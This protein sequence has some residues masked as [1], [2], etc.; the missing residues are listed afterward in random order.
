MRR[1][2]TKEQFHSE[3]ERMVAELR[4][5]IADGVYPQ[6]G[7]LPTEDVLVGQYRLSNKSVRKGLDTLAEE[8]M[9]EKI[10]RKGTRVKAQ[11]PTVSLTLGCTES[12]QR[13]LELDQLLVHFQQKHPWIRVK[14][15]VISHVP[16]LMRSIRDGQV[17]VM[18]LNNLQFRQFAES[19]R[20]DLLEPVPADPDM[21]AFL[22]EVFTYDST[23]YAQPVIFS[24]LVLCYNRAHFRE[25]RLPEPDGSWKWK[26]AVPVAEA[27]SQPDGRSGFCFHLLSGNRWP[28]FLLQSGE[29]FRPDPQGRYDIRGTR[30]LDSLRVCKQIIHNRSLF[31]MFLSESNDEVH[32][33]FL[34]GKLSMIMTTYSSLNDFKHTDLAYDISPLPFI[35]EPRTLSVSIGMAISSGTP[36]MEAAKELLAYFGAQ[37]AQELIRKR[38]LSIPGRKEVAEMAADGGLNRPSRFMLF[39]EQLFALRSHSDLGLSSEA[40]FALIGSLKAYWGN[41]IGEDE[42][43]ELVSQK[44]AAFPNI[45]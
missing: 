45:K 35:S 4:N 3:M 1:Q 15:V 9:I 32:G 12:I 17:D 6:G 20:L 26:D 43:C 44:I 33:L 13:D 28:V 11:K 10:P 21:Y 38:T 37:P 34:D 7:Y 5:G 36:R 24:P 23:C 39:R 29:S 16:D 40:L 42:L 25:R 30:L 8:G 19:G 14:P 22:T 2:T 41:I 18:T 27:L 31:P